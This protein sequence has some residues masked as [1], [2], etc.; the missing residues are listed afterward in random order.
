MLTMM[1]LTTI[2]IILIIK[3]TPL[4]ETKDGRRASAKMTSDRSTIMGSGLVMGNKPQ[5][6]ISTTTSV[7]E[8]EIQENKYG[9]KEVKVKDKD[10]K[11]DMIVVSTKRK[12]VTIG[13]KW[14]TCETEKPKGGRIVIRSGEIL[15][16]GGGKVSNLIAEVSSN[17]SKREAVTALNKEEMEEWIELCDQ[18]VLNVETNNARYMMNLVARSVIMMGK[19]M[20]TGDT[21]EDILKIAEFADRNKF[22]SRESIKMLLEKY[23]IKTMEAIAEID[24]E[25]RIAMVLVNLVA[26]RNA[27]MTNKEWKNLFMIQNKVVSWP[28]TLP[29]RNEILSQN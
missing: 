9:G 12:E 18:T 3:L 5:I 4:K 13:V 25:A 6:I 22:Y 20:N 16:G 19:E 7:I 1:C 2:I 17:V 11:L 8:L 26:W 29:H 27:M 24:F 28:D 15:T 10:E 14:D 21:M 23:D